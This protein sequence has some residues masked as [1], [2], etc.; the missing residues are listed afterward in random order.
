MPT[1]DSSGGPVQTQAEVLS[2]QRIGAYHV[3]TVVVSAIADRARPGQF[4]AVAVGGPSTGM[5]LRR[6]FAIYRA[7][8]HSAYAGTISFAFDVHGRGTEWLSRIRQGDQINVIG[9]LGRPFSLP[10]KGKR[11]LL[12]GGG[13]GS[14]TLFPLAEALVERDCAV[15]FLLGAATADRLFG[16]VDAK[17]FGGSVTITTDD[18]S[19]G[20]RGLVTDPLP[21]ALDDVD[22]IYACGPMPM[23]RAVSNAASAA[24]RPCQVAVE[25]SMACGIGICMTCVLPVVGDDGVTRMVRS[26]VDGPVFASHQMRWDDV[27]SVPT[28]AL[29]AAAMGV[30]NV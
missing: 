6:A 26:C 29:G 25:E 14:A 12:V 13:Y 30:A 23:L 8:P 24:R 11:A 1:P 27:G 16:E 21:Q 5:L 18:G 3:T 10:E 15:D 22:V 28:D 2:H 4:I 9:P 17:R 7:N 19:H 20:V